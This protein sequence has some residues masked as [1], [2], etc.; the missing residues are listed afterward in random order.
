MGAEPVRW[1]ALPTDRHGR[2][3]SQGRV[4]L[5]AALASGGYTQATLGARCG[6]SRGTIGRLARGELVTDSYALRSALEREVGIPAASWDRPPDDEC[7]DLCTGLGY[8]D[9]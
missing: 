5:V 1:R 6:V 2:V 4:L 7:T 3:R 8:P 9:P